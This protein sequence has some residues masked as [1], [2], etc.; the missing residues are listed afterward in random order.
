MIHDAL[1]LFDR[2]EEV[3]HRQYLWAVDE[4]TAFRAKNFPTVDPR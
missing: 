3:V 1:T 2:P 4:E